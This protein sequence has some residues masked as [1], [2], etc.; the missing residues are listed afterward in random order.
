MNNRLIAMVAIVGVSILGTSIIAIG[1]IS[2]IANFVAADAPYSNGV[3]SLSGHVTITVFDE[4]GNIRSYS[5]GDNAIVNV[6]ESCIAEYLFGVVASGNCT[7]VLGDYT[8]LALGTGVAITATNQGTRTA[9]VTPADTLAGSVSST[10]VSSGTDETAGA[11]AEVVTIETTF[12]PGARTYTEASLVSA[13]N[14]DM[15]AYQDM[16]DATL[17]ASDSV[18]VSWAI[19]IAGA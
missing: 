13:A 16:A 3:A 7:P 6:G 5:Q 9:L 4:F 10:T 18:K 11:S 12:S 17:G 2:P 14:A 19:T 8:T 15:L 1:E